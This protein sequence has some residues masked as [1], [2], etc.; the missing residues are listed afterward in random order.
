M[1]T[2]HR[3]MMDRTRPAPQTAVQ[4]TGEE[5]WRRPNAAATVL[6]SGRRPLTPFLALLFGSQDGDGR[7]IIRGV[8]DRP[9]ETLD[10]SIF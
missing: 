7:S 9:H 5:R 8:M 10:T 2:V 3:R 1:G 4:E 6:L